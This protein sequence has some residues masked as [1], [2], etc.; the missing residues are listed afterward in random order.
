MV[1][2]KKIPKKILVLCK[3]LKIRVT[4]K[5][6]GK[7]FYKNLNV[8]KKQIKKK[9]NQLKKQKK[10]KFGLMRIR[11][12][13]SNFGYPVKGY[14]VKGYPVTGYPVKPKD[15]G[16]EQYPSAPPMDTVQ[17]KSAIEEHVPIFIGDFKKTLFS[18]A[19][20]IK[21]VIAPTG[22]LGLLSVKKTEIKSRM[23]ILADLLAGYMTESFTRNFGPY[24]GDQDLSVFICKNVG[25]Q[26]KQSFEEYI[27]EELGSMA[28]SAASSLPISELCAQVCDNLLRKTNINKLYRRPQN[29]KPWYIAGGLALGAGAIFG[30]TKLLS[31]G[32]GHSSSSFGK[33][34]IKVRK[35]RKKSS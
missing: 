15:T 25:K 28:A 27:N 13:R 30:L 14:P 20:Q 6:G 3:K 5:R 7:R 2:I 26:M 10:M 32:K 8:L 18:H 11:K 19:G 22:I 29:M 4:I 31:F 33:R 17:A 21:K 16:T 23:K 35:T 12:K 34:Y 1:V 24:I 9:Q